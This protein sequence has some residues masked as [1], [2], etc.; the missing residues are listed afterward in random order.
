MIDTLHIDDLDGA[1]TLF[2]STDEGTETIAVFD[3]EHREVIQDLLAEVK[4]LR[5]EVERMRVLK[6]VKEN[7]RLRSEPTV[8]VDDYHKEGHL[9]VT[10]RF[11]DEEE[12]VGLVEKWE[13][14]EE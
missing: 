5:E 3:E 11:P 9:Y 1:V 12:Y 8:T 13:G 2:K 10:I 6:I 14:D 4:R 7:E